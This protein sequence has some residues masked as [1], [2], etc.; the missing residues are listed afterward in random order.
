MRALGFRFG[1]NEPAEGEERALGLAQKIAGEVIDA[2]AETQSPS[3]TLND[4]IA[5]ARISGKNT[6]GDCRQR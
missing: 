3:S 1:I 2:K 4:V 5:A 6:G